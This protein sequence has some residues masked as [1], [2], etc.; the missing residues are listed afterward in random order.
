MKLKLIYLILFSATVFASGGYDH[1][2]SAGKGN[3]DFSLTWNP[4]N[5]FK[6]GQSYAILGYGL[7]KTMDI[8]AYYSY[9]SD[10][11]SNYY[12]GAFY[13]FLDTKQLDLST[14]MGLR[15][16][17]D[18][19][20]IHLFLPQLLYTINLTDK[21]SLG[22]SVVNIRDQ[23]STKKLINLGTTLDIFFIWG[24]FESEKVKIDIS[25]GGFKPVLWQP[26]SG[27]W[28]GTYSVDFKIKR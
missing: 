21:T 23:R 19:P 7:T 16:Y 10:G 26:D 24:I 14:A 9:K 2:T 4:F 27:E 28:H 17:A 5:Y 22:G 25:V 20:D 12:V 1:G 11:F 18:Q 8:H 3:L 13:Q 6:K 15:L